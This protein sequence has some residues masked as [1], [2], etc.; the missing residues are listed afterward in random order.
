MVSQRF[1][2]KKA[3]GLEVIIAVVVGVYVVAFGVVTGAFDT[4]V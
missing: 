2:L 3:L 4:T 1:W